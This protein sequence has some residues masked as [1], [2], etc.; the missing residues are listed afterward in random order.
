MPESDQPLAYSQARASLIER[1]LLKPE[2]AAKVV[3]N[4]PPLKTLDTAAGTP[5]W[6]PDNLRPAFETALELFG[7]NR[8]MYGGDWPV[9]RLGGGYTRQHAAFEVLTAALAPGERAAIRADTATHVY[10]LGP[11]NG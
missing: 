10:R 7:A 9:S 3:V 2:E 4:P 5:D 6:T 1:G 11:T 8:L